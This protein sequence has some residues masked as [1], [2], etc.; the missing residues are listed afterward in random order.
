MLNAALKLSVAINSIETHE[1][2]RSDLYPD[3]NRNKEQILEEDFGLTKK[4]ARRFA[5]LTVEAV[6]KEKKFAKDND[7][8]PTLTHALKY[9]K[10]QSLPK[11][12][13]LTAPQ[14]MTIC[15]IMSQPQMENM[16]LF[17][18]TSTNLMKILIYLKLRM[19]MPCF[20][21]GRINLSLPLLSIL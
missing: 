2:T 16:I 7:E 20:I 9:V 14:M 17:T 21:Y 3:Q 11:R 12:K 4:Q 1:G 6:D 15:K 8:I 19:T 10:K 18:L 13:R 5:S